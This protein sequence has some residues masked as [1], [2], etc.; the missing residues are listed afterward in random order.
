MNKDTSRK[1]FEKGLCLP[2]GG[3]LLIEEQDKII[4]IILET[5]K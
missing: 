2:S 1:L 5:I 3:S 4:E